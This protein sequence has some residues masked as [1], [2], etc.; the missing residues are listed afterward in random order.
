MRHPT[1]GSSREG[2]PT[3]PSP[4]R[5]YSLALTSGESLIVAGIS[6]FFMFNPFLLSNMGFPGIAIGFGYGGF[7]L[8]VV[9]ILCVG[10]WL[11]NRLRR[12]VSVVLGSILIAVS[13]M[14]ML[15]GGMWISSMWHLLAI[16]TVTGMGTAGVLMEGAL[17]GDTS[18]MPQERE[19]ILL[20]AAAIGPLLGALLLNLLGI[21][22]LHLAV[23][24]LALVAA[25][26]FGAGVPRSQSWSTPS[27]SEE[28]RAEVTK[29]P[30]LV[31]S[32]QALTTFGTFMGIGILLLMVPM[33]LG[34]MGHSDYAVGLIVALLPGSFFATWLFTDRWGHKVFSS[35]IAVGGILA[36]ATGLYIMTYETNN[37]IQ[38]LQAILLLG[39]G[40]GAAVPHM[41]RMETV[42]SK[43]HSA[44]GK[45]SNPPRLMAVS[46]ML[47]LATGALWMATTY[48]RVRVPATLA[49]P[50]VTWLALGLG[51]IALIGWVFATKRGLE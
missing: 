11:S 39:V 30:V 14:L 38:L 41:R 34:R 26:M 6:V 25:S 29:L 50:S 17:V 43:D 15:L 9:A 49:L 46:A 2:D 48:D 1:H 7:C 51:A 35:F 44:V 5:F 10:P 42:S 31:G 20:A 36:A 8:G 33:S 21:G 22:G 28:P 13:A 40:A 32:A 45:T 27:L 24:V 19:Q 23:L 47:G 12:K 18:I 37:I 16:Y 4:Q 3:M